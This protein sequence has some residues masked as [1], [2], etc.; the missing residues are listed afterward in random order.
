M[1]KL[2][3]RLEQIEEE[4]AKN[5]EPE[6][7]KSSKTP[8]VLELLSKRRGQVFKLQKERE[9]STVTIELI[10]KRFRNNC[11]IDEDYKF[12]LQNSFVHKLSKKFYK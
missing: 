1:I 11:Q 5:Y 7:K 4:L 12:K 8:S 10:L 6:V 2:E 9:F 3:I